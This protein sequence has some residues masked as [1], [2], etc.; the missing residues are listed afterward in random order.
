MTSSRLT[1]LPAL[2]AAI[3]REL[4]LAAGSPGHEWRRSV[5]ATCSSAGP[6]ART[7]V[8]RDCH[9]AEQQLLLYTDSRSPKVAELRQDPRAQIVCWSSAL[10]WQLRLRCELQ[11]EDEGLAVSARWARV[12]F[13]P[14]AQ[15][16]IAHSAPGAVLPGP[17]AA[18]AAVHADAVAHHHF[19]VV[20]AQV[21]AIDW[22]ELHAQGHRR[23]LFE[24]GVRSWLAP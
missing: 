9:A 16:Y 24:A 11:V 8:L 4:G 23:A 13:A 15:D 20:T 21:L 18:Q 6:Q 3:W 14:S 1:D 5:V 7:M 10:N 19:A 12:R 17:A 2:E 22:L